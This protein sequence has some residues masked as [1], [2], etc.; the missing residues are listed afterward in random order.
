MAERLLRD[1]PG[2]DNRDIGIFQHAP[3]AHRVRSTGQD[4][5]F[6]APAQHRLDKLFFLVRR[7]VGVAEKQLQAGIFERVGDAP[8]G[9]GKVGIVDRWH[10]RRNEAGAPG[11]QAAGRLVKHVAECID[12]IHDPLA[13]FLRDAGILPKSPRDCHRGYAD[14]FG[15]LG[16]RQLLDVSRR[17][18][19][20]APGWFFSLCPHTY[21][22]PQTPRGFEQG[23][24]IK[25][26]LPSHNRKVAHSR[27]ARIAK[28]YL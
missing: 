20:P 27:A 4:D 28:G 9:V 1:F 5:A 23:S 11:R 18:V 15:D 19:R 26:S 6:R 2:L 13:R 3:R 22:L 12:G 8:R 16:H 17:A 14:I 7:V 21:R 24:P 10:Q 25:L